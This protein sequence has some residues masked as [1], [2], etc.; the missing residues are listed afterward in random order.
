MGWLVPAVLVVCL[1]LLGIMLAIWRLIKLAIF[2][3]VYFT[4]EGRNKRMTND[5]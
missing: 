3:E 2:G 5:E 4:T 1:V